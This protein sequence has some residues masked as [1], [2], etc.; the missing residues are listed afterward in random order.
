MIDEIKF[1]ADGLVPVII[2]DYLDNVVLMQAF[3]N[4]ESLLKTLDTQETWFYSRSRNKLWHKGEESG[5][6]QKVKKILVDCDKDC[7]LIKV[8]QVG[9]KACHTGERS[10][11]F[12]LWKS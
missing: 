12:T 3:M 9:G 1:N 5:H 10:C 8:E 2:Q 6:F 4:R 7:L 11:F